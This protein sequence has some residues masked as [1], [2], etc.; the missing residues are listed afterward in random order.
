M[1]QPR[2]LCVCVRECVIVCVLGVLSVDGHGGHLCVCGC[3]GASV[4][5]Q[6]Q[7]SDDREELC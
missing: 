4:E 7:V 6:H 1:V 2:T 3:V 5:P